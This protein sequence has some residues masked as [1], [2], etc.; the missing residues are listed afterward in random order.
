MLSTRTFNQT[1][2]FDKGELFYGVA[3]SILHS[4]RGSSRQR[5]RGPRRQ[6]LL[7]RTHDEH[8]TIEIDKGNRF[9]P[10]EKIWARWPM[11]WKSHEQGWSGGLTGN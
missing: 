9:H 3:K 10:S 2:T 6:H 4:I 7:P 1:N 11:S 8:T 5:K